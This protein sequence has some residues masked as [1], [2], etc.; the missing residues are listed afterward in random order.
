MSIDTTQPAAEDQDPLCISG[1]L[2]IENQ[3]DSIGFM[4]SRI[5][6]AVT[7]RFSALVAEHD[8]DPRRF[9]VL[10]LISEHE[11]E[12]QQAIALSIGVAK[13][14]M[15]AVV[16]ELES[17]GLLERRV[18]PI[19]RRQH[20]LHLTRKGRSV[21]DGALSTAAEYETFLR[22]ALSEREAKDMLKSLQKL[23]GLTGTT[24]GAAVVA[25]KLSSD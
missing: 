3:K 9:L 21:L 20:A 11:G 13:S 1:P 4:L 7:S 10:N 25:D 6:E 18:N 8:L 24:G 16:D 23:A 22:S 19:D 17:D 5:G 2:E 12:S 15:V 14:Q